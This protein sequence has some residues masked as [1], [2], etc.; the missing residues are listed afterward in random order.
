MSAPLSQ[1]RA[2]SGNRLGDSRALSVL[3]APPCWVSKLDACGLAN[4]DSA[5]QAIKWLAAQYT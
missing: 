1:L 3:Q 4:L 2:R 5:C